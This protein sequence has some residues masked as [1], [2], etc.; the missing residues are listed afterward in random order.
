MC[1]TLDMKDHPMVAEEDHHFIVICVHLAWWRWEANQRAP[2]G[3]GQCHWVSLNKGFSL[4]PNSGVKRKAHLHCIFIVID[5][6]EGSPI[7]SDGSHLSSC[8]L[9]FLLC[10]EKRNATNEVLWW[11]SWVV[12]FRAQ[13]FVS[14]I[15]FKFYSM[16]GAWQLRK[17]SIWSK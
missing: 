15:D 1:Y 2:Y 3:Q 9:S 7:Q 13:G 12:A 6:W 4:F 16:W 10:A 17:G 8:P 5:S 14:L 11:P